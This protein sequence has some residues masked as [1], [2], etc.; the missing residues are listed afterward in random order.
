MLSVPRS[1]LGGLSRC[2]QRGRESGS[3][4]RGLSRSLHPHGEDR[5]IP[6]SGRKA[7]KITDRA[8]HTAATVLCIRYDPV[9]RP[10]PSSPPFTTHPTP[11]PP[12]KKANNHD[13]FLNLRIPLLLQQPTTPH[14]AT[15]HGAGKRLRNPPPRSLP[16]RSAADL[17]RHHGPAGEPDGALH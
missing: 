17:G 14:A 7:K 10:F 13:R 9:S 16:A 6:S 3:L 4:F 5:R 1:F 8:N 11:D 2:S 15:A 12:S